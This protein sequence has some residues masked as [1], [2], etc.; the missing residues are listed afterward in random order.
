MPGP[1][2]RLPA[3]GGIR[4]P[5]FTC[6]LTRCGSEAPL[7]TSLSGFWRSRAS[8]DRGDTF[9]AEELRQAF[10]ALPEEGL[11]EAASALARGIEGAGEQRDSYWTRRVA[12]FWKAIW[13]KTANPSPAIADDLF[14][15]CIVAGP[16]FPA[17]L[18]T[19]RS[20]LVPVPYPSHLLL[21]TDLCSQFPERAFAKPSVAAVGPFAC[22]RPDSRSDTN[23]RIGPEL[24]SLAAASTNRSAACLRRLLLSIDVK[25]RSYFFFASCLALARTCSFLSLL[26]STKFPASSR[27]TAPDC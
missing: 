12:P 14:R 13:L 17:A 9:S 16:N 5:A 10:R 22:L 18:A 21:G 20:W 26:R 23:A 8:L 27:P 3:R 11:A 4:I 19:I 1:G 2:Y 25:A 15:L 24:G 6:T 7:P